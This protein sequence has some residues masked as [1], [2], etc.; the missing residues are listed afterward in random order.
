MKLSN[1]SL[2]TPGHPAD[3]SRATNIWLDRLA[4]DQGL[5]LCRPPCKTGS[6][7]YTDGVPWETAAQNKE[8]SK[9]GNSRLRNVG[10]GGDHRLLQ[11]WRPA[12]SGVETSCFR[13]K[14]GAPPCLPCLWYALHGV[15]LLSSDLRA[16]EFHTVRG[17]SCS[18]VAF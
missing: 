5:H 11:E 16:F 4:E 15:V 13:V 9:G 7:R 2:T 10:N 14:K 17:F 12:A 1:V 8:G 6:G 18:G 3:V